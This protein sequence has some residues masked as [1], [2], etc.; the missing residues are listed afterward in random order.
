MTKVE[1]QI[2]NIN[3]PPKL[4]KKS[5]KFMITKQ[6]K[7]YQYDNRNI[8]ALLDVAISRGFGSSV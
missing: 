2:F 4:P 6:I 8:Y 1:D 3:N 7:L 5:F